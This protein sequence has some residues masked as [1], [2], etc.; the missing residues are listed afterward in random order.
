[1][2]D[3]FCGNV[4]EPPPQAQFFDAVGVIFRIR[5][6]CGNLV[7]FCETP[8]APHHVK[9]PYIFQAFLQCDKVNRDV[10]FVQVYNGVENPPVPV[11]IEILRPEDSY[12]F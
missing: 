10:P 3:G 12:S 1:M 2:L 7:E 11:K 5:G 8:V 9:M 4:N 6:V